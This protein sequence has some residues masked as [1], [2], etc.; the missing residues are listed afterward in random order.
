MARGSLRAAAPAALRAPKSAPRCPRHP[1]LPLAP[2]NRHATLLE[3]L[4]A[5]VSRVIPGRSH[6]DRVSLN[7]EQVDA[8][9]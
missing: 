2:A 8:R 5:D 4:G 9:I 1:R 3:L 6:A 7:R